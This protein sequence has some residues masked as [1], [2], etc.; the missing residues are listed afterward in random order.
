MK[1]ILGSEYS[2]CILSLYK[3]VPGQYKNIM[4][5]AAY[6][7]NLDVLIVKYNNLKL[8]CRGHMHESCNYE[9]F[10]TIITSNPL[11]YYDENPHFK[12]EG[13]FIDTNDL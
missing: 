1:Y 2:L 11:K 12:P 5:S 6:A 13:T 10:G 8:W 9:L 3:S 7:S 4:L